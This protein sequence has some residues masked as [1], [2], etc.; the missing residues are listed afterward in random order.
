MKI[1]EAN[2]SAQYRE[3]SPRGE[4]NTFPPCFSRTV[5][6]NGAANESMGNDFLDTRKYDDQI[7]FAEREI[8]LYGPPLPNVAP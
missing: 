4:N 6:P 8:R 5:S 7:A 3:H 1:D 2:Q